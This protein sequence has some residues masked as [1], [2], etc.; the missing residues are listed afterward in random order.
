M[1]SAHLKRTLNF[2]RLQLRGPDGAK[3]E[4]LLDATARNLRKLAN[5]VPM[6]S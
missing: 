4:F 6:P 1:L 3:D 2:R 5:R